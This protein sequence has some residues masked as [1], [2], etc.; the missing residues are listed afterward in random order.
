MCGKD[1]QGMHILIGGAIIAGT[2]YDIKPL[3]YFLGGAALLAHGY[4]LLTGTNSKSRAPEKQ[5]FFTTTPM[6]KRSSQTHQQ[7]SSC[8][9]SIATFN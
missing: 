9:L 8:G 5:D 6:P 3:L 1:I 2:Y 4:Y 7:C